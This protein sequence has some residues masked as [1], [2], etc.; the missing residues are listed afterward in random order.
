MSKEV[1][2]PRY[3]SLVVPLKKVGDEAVHKELGDRMERAATTASS[4]EAEQDSGSGPMC[5]DTILGDV[6]AQTRFETTSKQFNDPPL[7]KGYT[8]GSGEDS[9][10]LLELMELCTQ[11]SNM[12][13]KNRKIDL[14]TT[15]EKTVNGER[16]IQALIDKKK[17]II[18]ETSIRS[19]LH[20]EDAGGTDCLPTATIFEE[21]TRMGYEKPSQKLTFYKGLFSP[22]WKF[23]IHTITQCLS[24]KSTAWNEFSST[25]A[26]LIICLATNQKFN[27][28]KYIFD[29]MVKHLEGGVKFLMYPRFL[30]VF[31][32]QQ[33]GD[34]SHHKKIYV[35][36]S[37][38]KKIFANMKREGKD[39]SR[40]IT[41][42]FATM[43]VQPN[44]EMGI[45]S[46]IPTDSLQTP[47]TTQPS[48][49]RSQKKQSRR[50]QRK[51]TAVLNLEK[52][53]DAQAK[54]IVDLKKRVQKLERNKKSR[55]TG[56]K[57]LR[58]VGMARRVESFEDK[59]SLGD[60]E[61][62][63][64]QGRSI[65]DIDKDADV[66][67]VDDTQ[68]RSDDVEMFD[69]N[70]LHGDELDVDMPV[71]EKQEQSAKERE[72]NTSV[73]DSVAPTTIEEITLAQTLIQIKAAKPK[74]VT[75][76]ATTTTTTRPK[77]RGVVVQEPSVFR[78]PQESQPSMIKD[79]GKEIMIE[80]E[81]PLKR[82]DQVALD[83]DLARNLQAQ[84]EAELIKEERLARLQTEEQGEITIEERSR[85]FVELMNQRKK[86]YAMLGAEEKRRK[87]LTK[88]QKRNLMSTYLKNMVK[89]KKGTEESSKGTEDELE[90]DKSKKAESNEEKAKG[91]RKKILGKKRAGKEKQ[92]ES[93]KRQRMV[94][95]KETDEHKEVEVDD[96]AELKK[97]L[98]I[99]K[100]DD[101]EIDAIPLATKP[102]VIV[103]YKLL[104]E[105]IMIHYQLIR[106]D[107]SSK[108][109]S[110]MIRMLQD[111]D[112]E[113]LQTLWK[114][115]KTKHGDTRP[116]DEHERVLWG[117]LKVMF[118]PDIR[119]DVW[120]NLQ[121]YTVTVWKLY[122]SCGVHFVST[123][124]TKVYAAGLQLLEDLLLSRG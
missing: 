48:S 26:S 93:S 60:H 58:K 98:V 1:G 118:E 55:T 81:V 88:S 15:K 77:V 92:Q 28:S 67:L 17:V 97:H 103:E 31:I 82:K 42:L 78:T 75:T 52:A 7:S 99:V 102:P 108:R 84:L 107:G 32:N 54:E 115:V 37:H 69:T 83:E 12:L 100:D 87:P 109:Y 53:K 16:Q 66:S 96:E 110:S 121:G 40:R 89:S 63:S 49:S 30:Q 85:L 24:A 6:D 124:G 8:L 120:R 105:G 51:D 5:Q 114:L 70:D 18:S 80:H 2:T 29:A 33:L 57:R 9:M 62:A 116:E 119:S 68:G 23:L 91:N 22:Q 122:D 10:K 56:L 74:F 25:M 20:L 106:A 59:D 50:K 35:N 111:I 14:A 36:P 4:L 71:G 44:Q 117:D 11:L 94:D 41:P 113:D 45:D 38:T 43:M 13:H 95:D 61:D 86:H 104:K 47:I 76:A 3:L 27:L 19:D 46:G 112:R 73:E 79:K 101:I 65:E 90:F 72:V 21:L 64:K 123:A 34:M 39:F